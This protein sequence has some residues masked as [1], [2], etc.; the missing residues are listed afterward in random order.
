MNHDWLILI[1][2]SVVAF[3][4]TWHLMPFLYIWCF[5][6]DILSGVH[7]KRMNHF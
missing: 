1:G 7:W 2:E 4:P 3:C 6:V 5:I